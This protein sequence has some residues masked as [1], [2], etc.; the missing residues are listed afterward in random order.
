MIPVT[1]KKVINPAMNMNISHCPISERVR[2]L[3]VKTILIIRNITGFISWK[4]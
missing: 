3:F 1:Q 2:W 4:S